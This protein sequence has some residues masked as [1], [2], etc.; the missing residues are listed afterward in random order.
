M[1]ILRKDTS[2]VIDNHDV[3]HRI[4]LRGGQVWDPRYRVVDMVFER[5]RRA[6][7]AKLSGGASIAVEGCCGGVRHDLAPWEGHH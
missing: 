7:V 3:P 2:R 1:A 5:L 4:A 6:P